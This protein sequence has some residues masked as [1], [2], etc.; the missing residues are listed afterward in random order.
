MDISKKILSDSVNRWIFNNEKKD[1]FIV[2]G[3]IR[4][5]L[6]GHIL[7]KDKD[8]VVKKNARGIAVKTAKKFNGTFIIFRKGTIYRV[9]LKHKAG[10]TRQGQPAPGF[11]KILDFSNLTT[12]I[13]NDLNERDFTINAIAWSPETDIIDPSEGRKDLKNN[14]VKAV[15][16]KNFG[17]DP[18]RTI[19]AYRIAAELGFSIEE[20]TRK[21]IKHYSKD[22]AM[23]ASERITEEFFKILSNHNSYKY[24]LEF[25]KDKVL[26]KILSTRDVGNSRVLS[27][28][29]KFLGDFDSFLKK[30]CLRPHEG[31]KIT[32]QLKKEVS[33]GLNSLGLLRLALLLSEDSISPGRLRISK[34]INNGLRDIHSGYNEIVSK[35]FETKKKISPE[36]L[37]KAFIAA[38]DRVLETAMIL[39]FITG[40]NLTLVRKKVDKFLKIKDK[41]LLNGNEVQKLLKIEAGIAIGK[42]LSSLKEQQL[43]G[44]IKTKADA[45][46]WL[47]GYF[48]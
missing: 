14:I 11:K 30:E 40:K 18:L 8:F 1:I 16:S 21:H 37:N 2:G 5:I 35:H 31:K 7:S 26:D 13:N 15:R 38:G 25:Y 48:T 45:R 36:K 46:R 39:S 9:V 33:Q 43:K 34:I 29:I 42:I 19:R 20:K 4:D 32:A 22:L 44:L 24:L 17:K 3:Y 10:L 23:V 41:I 27:R 28:K 6:L 12:T 47:A